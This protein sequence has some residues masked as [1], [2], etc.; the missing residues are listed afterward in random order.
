[1]K[2]LLS[3]MDYHTPPSFLQKNLD[4]PPS[5]YDFSKIPTPLQIREGHSMIE[6]NWVG[7]S[8]EVGVQ[9]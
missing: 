8:P 5:F 2:D 4:P 1:M 3:N 6:L 7:L 9:K